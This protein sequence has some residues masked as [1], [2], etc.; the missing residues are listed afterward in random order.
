MKESERNLEQ[1][2]DCCCPEP[3]QVIQVLQP[4][5]HFGIHLAQ[6]AQHVQEGPG[7]HSG[8]GLDQGADELLQHLLGWAHLGAGGELLLSDRS[9]RQQLLQESRG[10]GDG[11]FDLLRVPPQVLQDLVPTVQILATAWEI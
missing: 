2:E 9:P 6:A 11:A 7:V 4:L 1:A 10:V 8:F 5:V 3:T